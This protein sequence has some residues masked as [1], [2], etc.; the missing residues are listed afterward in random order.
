MLPGYEQRS[1]PDQVT[2]DVERFQSAHGALAAPRDARRCMEALFQPSLI[3]LDALIDGIHRCAHASV[4]AL[5]HMQTG[6]GYRP[7]CAD[8]HVPPDVRQH[9]RVGRHQPQPG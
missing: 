6:R 9:C 7:G 4:P 1:I 2:L 3:G 5:T 8:R